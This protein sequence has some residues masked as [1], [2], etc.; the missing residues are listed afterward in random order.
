MY[1]YTP[2]HTHIY[3]NICMYVIE[4]PLLG[5]LYSILPQ[6]EDTMWKNRRRCCEPPLAV[7]GSEHLSPQSLA[8]VTLTMK[9]RQQQLTFLSP[10]LFILVASQT[11]FQILRMPGAGDKE[12]QSHLM[13]L[14]DLPKVTQLTQGQI[15]SRM[16][17][18]QYT[19]LKTSMTFRTF[20]TGRKRNVTG[21]NC[22][23][24]C[25]FM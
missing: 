14:F 16:H 12:Y 24:C 6:E 17:A 11:L 13:N 23:E 10:S 8:C 22:Y 19:G 5:I 20:P 21:F 7:F 4:I 25:A 3:T 9:L 2:P 18:F 1:M 15:G